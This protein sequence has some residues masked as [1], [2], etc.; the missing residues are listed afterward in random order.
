MHT[1]L[2]PGEKGFLLTDIGRLIYKVFERKA[3]LLGYTRPQW[4]ILAYLSQTP[5]LTQVALAQLMEIEPITLSRH[6]DR[7][8]GEGLLERRG[9]PNDRRVKR[10]FLT[11]NAAPQLTQ[12]QA[13]RDEVLA[14]MFHGVPATSESAFKNT[15][16]SIRKNLV[17]QAK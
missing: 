7:M 3:C 16:E 15:L 14:L 4:H 11:S 8:E 6:L 9:D 1:L 5:G 2:E 10:L 12:I 13:V 17:D